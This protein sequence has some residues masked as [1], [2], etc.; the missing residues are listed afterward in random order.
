MK[1]SCKILSVFLLLAF[2][3]TSVAPVCASAKTVSLNKKSVVLAK[4]DYTTVS[5]NGAVVKS[6]KS[7]NSKVAKVSSKGKIRALKKGKATITVTDKKSKKYVCKV[8]VEDPKLNRKVL[9]LKVGAKYTL[10]LTGNTQ[11]VSWVSKNKKVATVNKKGRVTA[12]EKGKTSIV[13]KVGR[14]SFKCA[15]TVKAKNTIMSQSEFQKKVANENVFFYRVRDYDGDGN[16]EAFGII[17]EYVETYSDIYYNHVKI[18]FISAKN[19]VRC[20]KRNLLGSEYNCFNKEP[21]IAWENSVREGDGEIYIFGVKNGSCYEPEIS[22]KYNSIINH[23]DGTFEML[24][25]YNWITYC[26]NANKRTFTK[27]KK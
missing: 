26:Y 11:K 23:G 14:K 3:S 6:F 5:L 4:N 16:D 27:V 20:V 17:G 8:K 9:S 19:Q 22:G 24:G 21:Y 10:K 1:K 15:V 12:K 13:A 7:S 18:Y 2:V 25:N